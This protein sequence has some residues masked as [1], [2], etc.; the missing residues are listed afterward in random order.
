V[1]ERPETLECGSNILTGANA[2]QIIRCVGLVLGQKDS[3]YV[4]SEYLVE[5]VS[6]TVLKILHGYLHTQV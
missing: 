4:P 3:W 1:T 5:N 2:E 6:D